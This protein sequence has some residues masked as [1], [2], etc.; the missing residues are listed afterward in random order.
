MLTKYQE[1]QKTYRESHK[2][3]LKER[4]KKWR[5]NNRERSRELSNNHY[6]NLKMR[7]FE[8]LGGAKCCKC[9]FSDTRALQIDHINGGGNK[10][11]Y[12]SKHNPKKYFN[13]IIEAGGN[14][15]QVLCANCN[16]IKRFENNELN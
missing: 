3:E 1:Y 13:E 7:V 15:Y 5:V 10:E 12:N 14:G 11:R 8:V 2:E 6:A 9:G 4:Q 16:W